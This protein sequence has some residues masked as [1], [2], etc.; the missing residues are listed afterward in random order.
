VRRQSLR[1]VR[2]IEFNLSVA[3][4][5]LDFDQEER[6]GNIWLMETRD[7]GQK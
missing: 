4:N 5:M 6:T 1:N 2:L 7:S 3:P